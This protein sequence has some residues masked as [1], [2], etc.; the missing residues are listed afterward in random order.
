MRITTAFITALLTTASLAASITIT[1][2]T[3]T[4]CTGPAGQTSS[5]TPFECFPLNIPMVKS[6][7]YSGVPNTSTIN[8][9]KVTGAHSPCASAPLVL[10]NGSGCATA[11]DG[12]SFMDKY[13]KSLEK[14]F[15]TRFSKYKTIKP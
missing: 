6:I 10:G 11:P 2:F 4:N 5:V 14:G 3:G 12:C 13:T 9:F 8:F 1:T 15:I 7:S